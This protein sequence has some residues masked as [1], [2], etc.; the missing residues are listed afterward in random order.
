M[1]SAASSSWTSRWGRR[2]RCGRVC[3]GGWV[4]EWVGGES[5]HGHWG[6]GDASATVTGAHAS[7]LPDTHAH[8]L[9]GRASHQD[10]PGQGHRD[11]Q[12]GWAGHIPQGALGGAGAPGER[13]PACMRAWGGGMDRGAARRRARA[14]VDTGLAT[15]AR[16]H[17]ARPG[18][19][20]PLTLAL[21]PLSGRRS[22]TAPRSD[23][24]CPR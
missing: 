7:Q 19:A 15:R 18:A 12:G 11:A 6:M 23:T 10:L 16:T 24:G 17:T 5:L 1:E 8:A 22:W 4:G 9:A 14:R 13:P 21:P 3:V 2:W 20:H